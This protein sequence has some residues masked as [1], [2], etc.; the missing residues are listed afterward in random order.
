[1][2]QEI[3]FQTCAIAV[4]DFLKTTYPT[5]NKYELLGILESTQ[6]MVMTDVVSALHERLH[7][8]SETP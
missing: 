3:R 4:Y 8:S 5:I 6:A 7:K 2:T 1:M